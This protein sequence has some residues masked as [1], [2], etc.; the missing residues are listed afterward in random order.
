MAR[1]ARAQVC[2]PPQGPKRAPTRKLIWPL[3][4]GNAI[5]AQVEIEGRTLT[6]TAP[7]AGGWR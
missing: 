5:E 7:G 1:L 6:T 3:T 2:A 4:R